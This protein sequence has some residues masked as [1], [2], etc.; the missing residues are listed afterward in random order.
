MYYVVDLYRRRNYMTDVV[1]DEKSF[2]VEIVL[3]G[4]AKISN[5]S[6]PSNIRRGENLII[7][8]DCTNQGD[9]DTIYGVI[10]NQDTNTPYE[11]TRWE[12]TMESGETAHITS[13]IANVQDSIHAKVI[14]GRVE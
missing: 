7:E 9:R 10:V 14:V 5:L 12:R 2:T 3:I 1:T 11:G 8:Y 13:T 6:Y 4:N